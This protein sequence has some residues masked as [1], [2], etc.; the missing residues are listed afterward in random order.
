MDYKLASAVLGHPMS[1]LQ[2]GMDTSPINQSMSPSI[3][4]NASSSR[5]KGQ[6][7]SMT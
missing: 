3:F 6:G 5:Q 4:F 7:N 1:K 2:R